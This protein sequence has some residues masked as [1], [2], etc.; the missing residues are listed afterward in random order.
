MLSSEIGAN[1]L[2]VRHTIT[3][4]IGDFNNACYEDQH[5]TELTETLSD[6]ELSRNGHELTVS[7]ILPLDADFYGYS[8]PEDDRSPFAVLSAIGFDRYRLQERCQ[9]AHRRCTQ[10]RPLS[11]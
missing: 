1:S 10:Q 6:V 9:L 7:F 8:D 3:A 4:P 11:L 2:G 5:R